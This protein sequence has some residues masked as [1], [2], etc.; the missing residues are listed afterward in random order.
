MAAAWVSLDSSGTNC[1]I[2]PRR[3]HLRLFS[4]LVTMVTSLHGENGGALQRIDGPPANRSTRTRFRLLLKP[5]AM[6]F[7]AGGRRPTAEDR[8]VVL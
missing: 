1:P 7:I 6:S 2:H 8:G 3:F 5:A 4:A